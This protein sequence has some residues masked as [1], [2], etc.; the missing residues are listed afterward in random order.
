MTDKKCEKCGAP[1]VKKTGKFGPFYGCSNYP[2]CKFVENINTPTIKMACPKC[3]EG[4]VVV[5]RTKRGKIFYGCSQYPKCDFAAWD[6]PVPEPCPTCGKL[7]TKPIK[8]GYPV[9]TECGYEEKS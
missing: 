8:K 2:E 4:E 3:K 7:M 9:C 1:M 6:E 5:R